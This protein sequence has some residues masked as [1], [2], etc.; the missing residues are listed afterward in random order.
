MSGFIGIWKTKV[1]LIIGIYMWLVTASGELL[2]NGD[3]SSPHPR[4]LLVITADKAEGHMPFYPD[5]TA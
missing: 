2:I 4:L 3:Y 5:I 1:R